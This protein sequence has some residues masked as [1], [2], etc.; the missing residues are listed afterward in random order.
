MELILLGHIIGDFY[1]QTDKIAEKKKSSIKYMLIHCLMY[2]I[3]MEIC[4]YILSRK[5]EGTL[6]ISIFVFLIHLSIDLLKNK[7]EK[8][9]DKNAYKVFLIDQ[10]IHI[11]L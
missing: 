8:N 9:A 7:C 5:I 11:I 2:T 3:V 1:V 6:I 10:A 4:F